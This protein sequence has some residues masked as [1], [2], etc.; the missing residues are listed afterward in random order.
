MTSDHRKMNYDAYWLRV[1]QILE[2][3]G[4]RKAGCEEIGR[5]YWKSPRPDPFAAALRIRLGRRPGV[6]PVSAAGKPEENDG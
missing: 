4:E 1:N 6:R 5:Q 2:A 3:R